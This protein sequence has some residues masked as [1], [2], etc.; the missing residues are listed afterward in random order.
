MDHNTTFKQKISFKL[1]YKNNKNDTKKDNWYIIRP[2]LIVSH[3]NFTLFS[4]FY[5]GLKVRL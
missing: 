2:P 3:W 5:H 4:V 1:S